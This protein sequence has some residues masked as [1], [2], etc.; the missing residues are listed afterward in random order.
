MEGIARKARR[1]Q[2]RAEARGG[3]EISVAEEDGED[4][5]CVSGEPVGDGLEEVLGRANV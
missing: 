2:R 4:L 5:V 1:L 3:D